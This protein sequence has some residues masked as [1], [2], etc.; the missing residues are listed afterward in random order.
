M[1]MFNLLTTTSIEKGAMEV[2]V[3]RYDSYWCAK[4]CKRRKKFLYSRKRRSLKI[5]PKVNIS[6][7]GP[8]DKAYVKVYNRQW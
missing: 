7:V 2:E 5:S 3:G 4:L 6:C 1:I 8:F